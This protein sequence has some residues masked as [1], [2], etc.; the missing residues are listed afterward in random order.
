VIVFDS[1]AVLAVALNER[2]ADRV[3]AAVPEAIL[4]AA[5]L[6]EV[7]IVAERKGLESELVFAAVTNLGIEIVAIEAAH[8]RIAAQLRRAYP[9]LNLSLGDK[10]CLA[11]AL[12]RGAEVVTSDREMTKVGMGLRVELFR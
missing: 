11:L 10:L 1:S 5:N 8:A 3:L 7:L 9:A 4:S 2:G 6:A 12:N